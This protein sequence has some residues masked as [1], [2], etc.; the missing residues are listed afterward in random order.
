M[1]EETVTPVH[2]SFWVIGAIALIWNVLGCINFIVQLN[3][4]THAAYREVERAIIEGRPAWAMAGFAIAVFGG[5]I[6]SLLLLV[7][8][9]SAF[10]FFIASLLGVFVTMKHALAVDA[11]FGNAEIMGIVV[12][13]LAVGVFLVWYAKLAARKGWIS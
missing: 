1:Y 10:N 13:P 7:R 5:A 3:P 6:G 9:T 12:M 2:R 11:E 8:K 4:D